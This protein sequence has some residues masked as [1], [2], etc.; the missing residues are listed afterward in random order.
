MSELKALLRERAPLYAQAAHVVDTSA[1]GLDE[2]VE[3]VLK[4]V[5]PSGKSGKTTVAKSKEDGT[6]AP[7]ARRGQH[8]EREP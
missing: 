7:E 5:K 4:A 1:V 8:K 3:R 2:T 6:S